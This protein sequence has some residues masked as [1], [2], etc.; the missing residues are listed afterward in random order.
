MRCGC[1]YFFNLLK[2]S[3]ILRT[4]TGD[5]ISR[6]DDILGMAS[7]VSLFSTQSQNCSGLQLPE[8]LLS[9]I[10]LKVIIPV[11]AQGKIHQVGLT[12]IPAAESVNFFTCPLK[13]SF[14]IKIITQNFGD[15]IVPKSPSLDLNQGT[16]I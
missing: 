15:N 13:L 6:T 9:I 7:W 14:K 10:I 1:V 11:K 8:A 2:T 4:A 12:P 16:C 5:R 3:T